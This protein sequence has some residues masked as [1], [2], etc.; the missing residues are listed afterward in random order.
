MCL[1][2]RCAVVAAQE[3]YAGLLRLAGLKINAL[4]DLQVTVGFKSMKVPFTIAAG[5]GPSVKLAFCSSVSLQFLLCVR[6]RLSC[7]I[8]C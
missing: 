6:R 1:C 5:D 4:T 2:R 7:T 3:R 8:L